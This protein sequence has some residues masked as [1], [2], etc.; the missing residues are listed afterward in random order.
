MSATS[1]TE[2]AALIAGTS[3]T[4]S[5][6]GTAARMM[7]QPA[8]S[9][10]RACATLPATSPAGTFSIDCTVMGLPPPIVT[11]PSMFTFLVIRSRPV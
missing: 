2:T 3:L 7:S 10:A 9:S 8:A 4:A 6:S 5:R 1:G 11:I